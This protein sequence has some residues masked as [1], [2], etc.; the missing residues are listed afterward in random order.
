MKALFLSPQDGPRA[1]WLSAF[2]D[3]QLRDSVEDLL[4]DLGKD[5]VVWVNLEVFSD[6]Q[7][8]KALGQLVAAGAKVVALSAV[9]TEAQ[10]FAM[11]AQGARGYCHVESAPEQLLEVARVVSSNA[12]W[13]PPELVQRLAG[14]AQRLD[15]GS[16]TS[17]QLVSH[18]PAHSLA[19]FPHFESLTAREEQV[20]LMV[21]RGFNN[22]EIAS[23]LEVSERTVKANL[24]SIFHKLSLRDRV[25]LA[26]Y[27]NRLP[28]H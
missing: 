8:S 2:P 26:L 3:L 6:S 9:P 18:T 24:T 10:A 7:A 17:S 11:L 21:G 22:R 1:R 5:A 15:S 25:Q 28:I 19:A 27:V 12:L 23:A 16:S 4:G 20:A 13:M 14:V